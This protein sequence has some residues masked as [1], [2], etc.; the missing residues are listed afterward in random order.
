MDKDKLTEIEK[1][2][3]EKRNKIKNIAVKMDELESNPIVVEYK[4]TITAFKNELQAF[5]SLVSQKE[6]NIQTKCK[7]PLLYFIDYNKGTDQSFC[8]MCVNCNELVS[9]EIKDL[10]KG[11][12][13]VD[14]KNGGDLVQSEILITEVKRQF[15]VIK[16]MKIRDNIIP[17]YQVNDQ[18]VAIDV[19]KSLCK[20]F[21]KSIK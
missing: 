18:E 15:D 4:E 6:K 10:A 12:I 1:L 2:I 20:T 16:A 13:V 14:T 8:C 9:K 21:S 7:H 5:T 17:T 11:N 19:A 3:E